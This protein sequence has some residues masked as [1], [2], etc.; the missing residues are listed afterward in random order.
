LRAAV[1]ELPP[2]PVGVVG[3]IDETRTLKKGIK[4]PGVQRQYLGCVG[5]VAHGI[6]TVHLVV[7]HGKFKARLDSEL[8]LP[9]S[10]EADRERCRDADIPDTVPYRPKSAIALELLACAEQNGWHLDWLTFD[11]G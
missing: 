9:E 3:I 4:T 7:A 11:E 2:D 10:W 8:F 1:A 5:K 6:V